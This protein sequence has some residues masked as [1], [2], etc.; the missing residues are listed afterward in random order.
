MGPPGEAGTICVEIAIAAAVVLLLVLGHALDRH[1]P[2][3]SNTDAS[4]LAASDHRVRTSRIHAPFETS[5]GFVLRR[6]GTQLLSVANRGRGSTT[7][8]S[9]RL[10]ADGKQQQTLLLGVARA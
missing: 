9:K 8:S 1:A 7:R 4:G 10:R 6:L 2:D 5:P 3:G